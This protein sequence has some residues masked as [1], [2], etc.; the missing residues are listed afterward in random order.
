MLEELVR[1]H[2]VEPGD[3]ILMFVPESGRFSAAYALITAVN[4]AG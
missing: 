1:R 4:G 3:R 2:A